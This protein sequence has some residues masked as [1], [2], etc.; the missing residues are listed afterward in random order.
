MAKRKITTSCPQ[1][2]C[3]GATTLSEEELKE[4]YGD[5][6]NIEMECHDCVLAME[7]SSKKEKNGNG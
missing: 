7:E 5:V 6:E 1:C 4:R 3:S 2:G